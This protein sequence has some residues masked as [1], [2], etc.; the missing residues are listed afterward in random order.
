MKK[1]KAR[2][3]RIKESSI[4]PR[5]ALSTEAVDDWLE[6]IG[7]DVLVLKLVYNLIV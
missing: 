1:P 2:T 4:A 6:L 7:R 3:N 5:S